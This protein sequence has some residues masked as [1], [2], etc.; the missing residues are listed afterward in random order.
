MVYEAPMIIEME[1]FII[2]I[3]DTSDRFNNRS[4]CGTMNWTMFG[5]CLI[6]LFHF[7]YYRH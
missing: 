6:G 5:I 2:H 1:R 3:L 4:Q 7:Y